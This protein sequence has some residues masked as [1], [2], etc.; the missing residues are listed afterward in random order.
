M[1]YGGALI[2]SGLARNLKN[3]Y[4]N[5][6]IIFI[7]GNGIIEKI[8]AFLMKKPKDYVVFDNNP[9][10]YFVVDKIRWLFFERWKFNDNEIIVIDMDD[11]KFWYW[12][13]DTKKR[14]IYKKGK[15]AI[16]ISCESFGIKNPIL[17]PKIV[18]TDEEIKKVDNVLNNHN[19]QR[20]KF[21]CIEPHVKEDFTP[22]KAWFWDR[23]QELVERLGNYFRKNNLDIKIV[24]VG[25]GGKRVLDGVID[26]TGKFTF[27]ETARVLELSL[28]FVGY[29]GG[30]VHLSKAVGKRSVVLISAWEP[31][32]LASYPDDINI[33]KD[34]ECKHCGLKV[35]CHYNR[36]C[37]DLI[38]VDEVFN[39]VI[40]LLKDLENGETHENKMSNM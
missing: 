4:P 38:T 33:Y 22:N 35:P 26:L 11:P 37:M 34:V 13:K 16:E 18:L 21:I 39:E 24:Q 7:Y 12:E 2:W 32:E 29:M 6:K 20:N 36:E 27:R 25:A 5:K 19:L 14:T 9:D 40:N 30:L 31:K 17:K 3:K 8:K 10:I 23:W 28:F 1:G 15:H